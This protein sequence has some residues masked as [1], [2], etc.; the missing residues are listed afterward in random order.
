MLEGKEGGRGVAATLG[1]E[2]GRCRWC[3]RCRV[4]KDENVVG[5]LRCT[6]THR[7]LLHTI[8]PANPTRCCPSRLVPAHPRSLSL[9][10]ARCHSFPLVVVCRRPLSPFVVARCRL[11]TLVVTCPDSLSPVSVRCRQSLLAVPPLGLAHCRRSLLQVWPGWL[12]FL[13]ACPHPRLVVLVRT[14]LVLPACV[15]AALVLIRTC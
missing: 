10:S 1:L 7:C 15:L 9:I 14:R 8:V 3:R 11:S 2:E 4:Q 12:S 13:L 5:L 6:I